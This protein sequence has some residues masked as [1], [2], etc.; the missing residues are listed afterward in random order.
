MVQL[1]KSNSLVIE[2]WSENRTKNVVKHLKGLPIG[3]PIDEKNSRDLNIGLVQYLNG[4]K[5][6]NFI[7]QVQYSSHDLNTKLKMSEIQITSSVFG[8]SNLSCFN[9]S[10]S[11]S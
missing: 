9:E 1:S 11:T 2:W 3:L 5:L 6:P 8:W 4:S 7:K 10:V